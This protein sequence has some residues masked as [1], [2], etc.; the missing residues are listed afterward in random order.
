[1][2]AAITINS[3]TI[4]QHDCH[5]VHEVVSRSAV[6]LWSCMLD[7]L[8]PVS[9]RADVNCCNETHHTADIIMMPSRLCSLS[10]LTATNNIVVSVN[11]V[12]VRFF[13]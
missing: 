2:H 7:R 4:A 12:V 8:S 3:D 11:E 5:P 1:M 13:R 9:I 10:L 6:P